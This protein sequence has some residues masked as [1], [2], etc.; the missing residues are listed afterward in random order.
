[1]F[2]FTEASSPVH[3][4]WVPL[5]SKNVDTLANVDVKPQNK[6]IFD[7]MEVDINSEMKHKL[8]I[9][10]ENQPSTSYGGP[11]GDNSKEVSSPTLDTNKLLLRMSDPI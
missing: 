8:D 1:M 3:D 2:L 11:R 4:K 7:D 10:K 5:G 9:E 6:V